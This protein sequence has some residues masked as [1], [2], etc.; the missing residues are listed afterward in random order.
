MRFILGVVGF[1]AFKD[2]DILCDGG[3]EEEI[4]LIVDV[5]VVSR[6]VMSSES[7]IAVVMNEEAESLVLTVPSLTST[8][9]LPTDENSF[10][11]EMTV[12]TVRVDVVALVTSVVGV[13][14][15]R[16]VSIEAGLRDK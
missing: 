13:D 9:V 5:A 15:G 4:V 8:G 2:C 11:V 6:F 16:T 1:C 7:T 3:T 12:S 14:E 10:K